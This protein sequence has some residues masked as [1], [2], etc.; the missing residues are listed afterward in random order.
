MAIDAELKEKVGRH[1]T[2]LSTWGLRA[3]VVVAARMRCITTAKACGCYVLGKA[4]WKGS[5]AREAIVKG[6][7]QRDDAAGAVIR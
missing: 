4:L 6:R 7:E 2:T 3:Y 1:A 5:L